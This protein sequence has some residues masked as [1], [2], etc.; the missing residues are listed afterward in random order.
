MKSIVCITCPNGCRLTVENDGT[1]TGGRCKRGEIYAKAELTC[2]MRTLTT[3]VSTK[4]A[5]MAV[6]PV[7]TDGEIPKAKISE[8]ISALSHIIIDNEVHC[9]DVIAQDLLGLGCNVIATADLT[10]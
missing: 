9:G 7:R 6:L 4:F 5:S 1:V 10:I 2:P 8:A 3:T